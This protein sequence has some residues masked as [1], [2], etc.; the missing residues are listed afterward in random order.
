MANF[1][2][3]IVALLTLPPLLTSL[4]AYAAKPINLNQQ[5]NS[6]HIMQLNPQM[7]FNQLSQEKDFNQTT[8]ERL[9]QTYAGYKVWGA[10]FARHTTLA[11]QVSMNGIIYDDLARDLSHAPAYIFNTA[12]AEKALQQASE[13]YRK[14][15]G[16]TSAIQ[17]P[18]QQLMVYVDQQNTAHWAYLISF[19]VPAPAIHTLPSKSRYIL[20]AVNFTNYQHWDDIQTDENVHGGGFGGN[21]KMGKRTYDGE[22][23]TFPM[24]AM[25]RAQGSQLCSLVNDNVSVEDRRAGDAVETF[26]CKKP[27][28]WRNR[29]YW[30]ADQDAVNGGYSPGNDALYGGEIIKQLY[31]HW[32]GVPVLTQ[33]GKP[34]LLRMRVHDSIGDNAYWDGSTMNFGDGASFFYPLTSLGVAAHEISHGFTQQHS[35]LIYASQPGGM[36]EA[37]SDMAA[38]AAEYYAYHHN[39]WQIGPEIFKEP[40]KA[41]R[42]MDQPSKDCYGKKPGDWCSIDTAAQYQEGI[43]VHFSSGIYNHVF[44]LIGTSKGWDTHKAFDVMVQANKFYWTSNSSFATAACGVIQAAKDYGY[45]ANTVKEAFN[46]VAVNTDSCN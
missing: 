10:D 40:G 41:L 5:P 8:H 42:Y 37:F 43:D 6:Y 33:N 24:L 12:Q 2:N 31:Q 21:I 18:N 13:L 46:K 11:G 27:N 36:N 39:S 1:R 25:R 15:S 23:L 7:G 34:M 45:D 14:T 17:N 4:S 20:D 9:Q 30:D 19:D 35:G 3:K 16:N 44:Y 26:S 38:Q 32:Y 22:L 28:I 29:V